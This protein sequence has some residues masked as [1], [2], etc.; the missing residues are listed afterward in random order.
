MVSF[1][2]V[3]A[4]SSLLGFGDDFEGMLCH[5]RHSKELQWQRRRNRGPEI[6]R[7]VLQLFLGQ[8]KKCKWYG[9]TSIENKELAGWQETLTILLYHFERRDYWRILHV[10]HWTQD[11]IVGVVVSGRRGFPLLSNPS[12]ITWFAGHLYQSPS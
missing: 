9:S 8:I 4:A 1:T 3:T 12:L 5:W 2:D 10:T 11:L 6:R 7:P